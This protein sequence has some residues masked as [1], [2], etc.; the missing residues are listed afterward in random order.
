[1]AHDQHGRGFPPSA[2]VLGPSG[3]PFRPQAVQA[4]PAAQTMPDGWIMK[5]IF[6]MPELEPYTGKTRQIFFP[7]S[8][9]GGMGV[10]QMANAYTW[11][12]PVAS[13]VSAEGKVSPPGKLLVFPHVQVCNI[14]YVTLT[15]KIPDWWKEEILIKAEQVEA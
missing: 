2:G 14:P 6:T 11:R 8:I 9:G 10:L 3:Q 12:A 13:A 7:V 1:M 4:G 15:V 5:I